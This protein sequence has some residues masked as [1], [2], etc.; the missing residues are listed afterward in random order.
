[1]HP[2]KGR[3]PAVGPVHHDPPGIPAVPVMGVAWVESSAG[4]TFEAFCRE[5][6]HA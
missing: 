2:G 5:N 6:F 4:E 1:M 3:A